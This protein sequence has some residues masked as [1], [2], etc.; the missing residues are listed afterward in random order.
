V[1]GT[2]ADRAA[3]AWPVPETRWTELYLDIEQRKLT[4]K[5]AEGEQQ[6]SFE[7]MGDGLTFWTDPFDR[8]TE[9]TG[10]AAASL[11]LSSIT[12]E[13][14]LFLTLRVQ[15]PAGTD[16]SF[17]AAM[18][19]RGGLGFGWLRSS[20]RKTD[21]GRSQPNRPWHT[22]DKRQPLDPGV[23]VDVDVEIWPFS[24]II[25]KDKVIRADQAVPGAVFERRSRGNGTKG[26]RYGDWALTAT[27]D[28]REFLLIRRLGREKNPYT[29][30]LCW[31]PPG[32]PAT[33]TY[34]ITIAGRR[35][36]VE[37]G[38]R[39]CRSSEIRFS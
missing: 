32:R 17:P 36:P 14:D 37:I 6:G 39:C 35:W 31:A 34:F 12:T 29:F 4:P 5:P 33:M 15:D 8:D 18:D 1:D 28:P 19:P 16:V 25:A 26:P 20:L 11:T 3:A 10:P 24:V 7:A 2:F 27:A 13:A 21:P 23:P 9:L 30:Y 22:F 38:H